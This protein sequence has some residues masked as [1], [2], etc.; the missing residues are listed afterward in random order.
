MLQNYLLNPSY[1]AVVFKL[2]QARYYQVKL[3]VENDCVCI[4]SS[5]SLHRVLVNLNYKIV[6]GVNL[7]L[8]CKLQPLGYGSDLRI[9]MIDYGVQ[10]DGQA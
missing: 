10:M 3:F 6:K 7:D 8:L 4:Y 2:A 5:R 1:I 9:R